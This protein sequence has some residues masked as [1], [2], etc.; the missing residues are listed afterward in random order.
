LP[1]L[2]PETLT[3]W[4]RILAAL[5]RAHLTV[6]VGPTERGKQW[7]LEALHHAGISGERVTCLSKVYPHPDYLRLFQ[8]IDICLDTFPYHGVTTT[9]EA[10]TMGVPVVSL[11]GRA[12]ASR[13]GVSFLTCLGHPE[14]VAQTPDDYVAIAVRLA[15]DLGE[16]QRLREHL[17]QQMRATQQR[18]A[19]PCTRNLE[20]AYRRMWVS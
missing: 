3:L 12:S 17:A 11:A 10:L 19:V 6:L 4:S 2:N 16:L 9:C 13:H 5:P 15:S 7:L 14:W 1:K 20:A 8:G 18:I